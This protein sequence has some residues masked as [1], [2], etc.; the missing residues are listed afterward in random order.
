MKTMKNIFIILTI[1]TFLLASP[2]LLLAQPHP[3]GGN[4]PNTGGTHNGPVG[5]A[6]IGNGT[7]ILTALAMAY[8]GRKVYVVQGS[9]TNEE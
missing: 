4:A 3:N 1:V 9:D 2:V 8:A 6:P 5:G 7:F